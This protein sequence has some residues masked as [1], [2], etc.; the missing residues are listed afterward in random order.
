SSPAATARSSAILMLTSWSEASTPAELSIASVLTLPPAIANSIRARWVSPRLPP[1]TTTR[2]RRSAASTRTPSLA[3]SPTSASSSA[4]A[5]TN[6]PMPPFQSMSTGARRIARIS[7]AG[8]RAAGGGR[9]GAHRHGLRAPRPNAAA[10]RDR[11]AVVVVPGRAR[12]AEQA[13]ALG[14]RA[15]RVRV[16]VEEQV[17]VVEGPDQADPVGEQHPVAEDVA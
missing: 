9:L 15:R 16:R 4:A 3:L 10:G 8:V 13:P 6:V 14:E 5:L 17:A 12:Q 1:S 11:L 2:A 7:P